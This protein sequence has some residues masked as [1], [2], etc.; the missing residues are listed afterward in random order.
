MLIHE[1][2]IWGFGFLERQTDKSPLAFPEGSYPENRCC[3]EFMKLE[4]PRGYVPT[5]HCGLVSQ[6]FYDYDKI[7]HC[8]NPCWS[9][10]LASGNT[11]KT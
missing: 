8:Y 2:R 6:L 9:F 10:P 4:L 11:G 7:L 3:A 5:L 1:D